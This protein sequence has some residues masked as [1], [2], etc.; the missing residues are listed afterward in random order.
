MEDE[1]I[2]M[3]QRQLQRFQVLQ[4][5]MVG[6]ITLKEAAEKMGVSYRQ[7]Q[8][9]RKAF[10][11]K[12]V[13]GLIR[14]NIG[15]FPANRIREEIHQEVLRLSRQFFPNSMI[16]ISLNNWPNGSKSL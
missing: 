1:K 9:M 12:G 15:R 10:K 6:K 4:L 8:R 14:G 5:V 3:S 11:E 2:T 16:S 13:R 7:I